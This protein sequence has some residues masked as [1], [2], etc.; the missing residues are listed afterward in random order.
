MNEYIVCFID[1]TG[2]SLMSKTNTHNEFDIYKKFMDWCAYKSGYL[3]F[4]Y[5]QKG[6]KDSIDFYVKNIIVNDYIDDSNEFNHKSIVLDIGITRLKPRKHITYTN[7][8][9]IDIELYFRKEP[10][11]KKSFNCVITDINSL[12]SL[13]CLTL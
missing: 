9:V 12:Y 4:L 7:S 13:D 11:D 10:N 3:K 6:I 2:K 1:G 8:L 5:E